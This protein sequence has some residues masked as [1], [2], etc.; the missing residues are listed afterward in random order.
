MSS[1]NVAYIP[2]QTSFVRDFY[3]NIRAVMHTEPS[4]S[5]YSNQH[6]YSDVL[7]RVWALNFFGLP[8]NEE[9]FEGEEV[10][11]TAIFLFRIVL[12]PTK[13][14]FVDDPSEDD[15]I[16]TVDG[17]SLVTDV[18]ESYH[19][20]LEDRL[21]TGYSKINPGRGGKNVAFVRIENTTVSLSVNP[22]NEDDPFNVEEEDNVYLALDL[23]PES[24]K[25]IQGVETQ[26]QNPYESMVVLADRPRPDSIY[27]YAGV[28]TGVTLLSSI[29]YGV[30]RKS[31][32]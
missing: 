20:T 31:L 7:P 25:K 3:V 27:I 30:L 26:A 2:L 8:E 21:Q 6:L 29:L 10:P 18:S 19:V 17:A 11:D 24:V 13:N 16:T 12:Y 15:Y 14:F 4:A 9:G 5:F 28:L 32:K 23:D 1:K 22:E